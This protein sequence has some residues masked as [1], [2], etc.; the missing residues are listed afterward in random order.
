MVVRNNKIHIVP[1]VFNMFSYYLICVFTMIVWIMFVIL[2]AMV[3]IL[4]GKYWLPSYQHTYIYKMERCHLLA[5]AA[6][7]ICMS[8]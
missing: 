1:T 7:I 2:V 5:I 6:V 4:S 3:T 8:T